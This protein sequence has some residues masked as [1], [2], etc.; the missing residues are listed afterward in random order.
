MPV[1][2]VTETSAVSDQ[3]FENTIRSGIN[4][5]T[6]TLRGVEGC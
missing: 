3:G 6:K 1:P 5:A 4:R 2:S